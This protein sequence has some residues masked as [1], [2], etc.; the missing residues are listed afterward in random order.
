[1]RKICLLGILFIFI[2]LISAGSFAGAGV[3]SE[4]VKDH[5]AS[6]AIGNETEATGNNTVFVVKN[7]GDDQPIVTQS[8]GE[9]VGGDPS[10]GITYHDQ[11]HNC[12]VGHQIA[13]D[14]NGGVHVSW[15]WADNVEINPREVHYCYRNSNG[16]WGNYT[17]VDPAYRSGYTTLDIKSSGAAAVAYHFNIGGS[18]TQTKVAQDQFPGFGAFQPTSV[19]V[20]SYPSETIIWPK[21]AIGTGDIAHIVSENNPDGDVMAS[22][23]YGQSNTDN[24]LANGFTH[25]EMIQQGQRRQRLISYAVD[26]SKTGQK[27]VRAFLWGPDDSNSS[28]EIYHQIRN[29]AYVQISTDGGQSW[30][31]TTALTEYNVSDS[32]HDYDLSDYTTEVDYD[33]EEEFTYFWEA[34]HTI[35]AHVDAEDRVHVIWT[36]LM[37]GVIDGGAD[38]D[39]IG[40]PVMVGGIFHWDDDRQTVDVVYDDWSNNPLELWDIDD[41][42]T[43]TSAQMAA[44][45]GAF[46]TTVCAPTMAH[47]TNNNLFVVFTKFFPDDYCALVEGYQDGNYA[48]GKMF[49]GEIMAIA[50]V[51]NGASWFSNAGQGEAVNLTNSNSRDCEPGECDDD[52]YPTVA[53]R[54]VND[55]L[56]ILYINDKAPG[57]YY[58]TAAEEGPGT[59]NPVL[60]LPVHIEDVANFD[61]IEDDTDPIA[62]KSTF[63]AQNHPNPFAASTTIQYELSSES[64]VELAVYNQ[65]GQL[66][67]TLVQGYQPAGS[68]YL[69]WNGMND[70][71]EAVVAGVYFYQLKSDDRTETKKMI[72]L[73]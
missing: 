53:K 25:W 20:V 36:Q 52:R 28:G 4:K 50:S 49:N 5:S 2:S 14:D 8:P 39:T 67:K 23:Y 22:V 21:I 68:H 17:P 59:A 35:E 34:G 70:V 73:K 38:P 44:R 10:E 66:V 42:E 58:S 51:D 46:K 37:Q 55:Q 45:L 48:N 7:Y 24:Y 3:L 65:T 1:M 32:N 64:I 18:N 43:S 40:Y 57:R 61:N 27:V 19:D 12:S 71:G 60:Y 16:N 11:Q 15:M 13:V 72:L 29:D 41:A 54:V 26:A 33:G 69:S 63:L 31:E 62:E 30:G 6:K 47:D 56:H 9:V